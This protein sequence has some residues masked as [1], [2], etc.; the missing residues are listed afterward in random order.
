MTVYR[1]GQARLLPRHN[2][3]LLLYV[4]PFWFRRS[5]EIPVQQTAED[6]G[7]R[8]TDSYGCRR[9]Q[10]NSPDGG[11]RHRRLQTIH[12][13]RVGWES[14][15]VLYDRQLSPAHCPAGA[16]TPVTTCLPKPIPT[17]FEQ[18]AKASYPNPELL[19]IRLP[20]CSQ[21]VA[22][23][24]LPFQVKMPSYLL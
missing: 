21:I 1:A 2:K 17:G 4:T 6:I 18:T 9:R 13:G 3:G 22:S 12:T 8:N 16:L 23:P 7:T 14:V 15:N 10:V 11:G 24:A 20:C 19:L 5:L